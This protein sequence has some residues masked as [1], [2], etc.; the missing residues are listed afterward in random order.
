ME[1]KQ[2]KIKALYFDGN[3]KQ[4]EIAEMLNTSNKYVSRILLKDSRYKEEKRKRKE[5]SQAEHKKKTIEYMQNKRKSKRIDVV[6]EQ[7]KQ[8]HIQASKELS[9]N[10][11]ISNQAYRNWNSSI[12]KYNANTKSYHIKRGIQVG[13]DVP[14]KIN[15]K[16]Y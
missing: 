2:E 14:K 6:Y 5:I 4:Y 11:H 7:L 3:Y 13:F 15:W 12:Y 9:V 1:N 10:K 8:M 16:N